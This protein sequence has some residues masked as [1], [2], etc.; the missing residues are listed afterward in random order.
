MTD[1][2]DKRRNEVIITKK[3]RL[4]RL[5]DRIIRSHRDPPPAIELDKILREKK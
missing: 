2:H 5:Y 4:I 1:K 3:G